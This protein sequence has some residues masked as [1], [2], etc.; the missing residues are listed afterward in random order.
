[1]LINPFKTDYDQKTV[2]DG[3]S[4]KLAREVDKG[5][6]LAANKFGWPDVSFRAQINS[7]CRKF[8]MRRSRPQEAK[9]LDFNAKVDDDFPI[10]FN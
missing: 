9:T 1:M 8:E 7:E 4:K 10:E 5:Y 3:S 2:F 6:K